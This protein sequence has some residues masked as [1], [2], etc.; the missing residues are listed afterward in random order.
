MLN[1]DIIAEELV[2]RLLA[3]GIDGI[4]RPLAESFMLAAV[5]DDLYRIAG[6]QPPAWLTEALEAPT[7][8]LALAR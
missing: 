3:D 1:L 8:A 4:D 5:L 7:F 6:Q 2:D